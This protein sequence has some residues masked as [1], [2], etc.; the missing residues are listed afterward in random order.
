MFRTVQNL[1]DAHLE[2][3]I[4]VRADPWPA[5]RDVAKHC[6]QPF[7]CQSLMY[8]IDPDKH[9][10]SFQKPCAD[11]FCNVVVVDLGLRVNAEADQLFKNLAITVVVR[12]RITPLLVI[13]APQDCDCVAPHGHA[14]AFAGQARA[15]CPNE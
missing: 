6:V 12:R 10:V 14:A 11:F 4:G 5:R 3:Y 15:M 7:S 2:N 9:A 13:A 1:L 8:R